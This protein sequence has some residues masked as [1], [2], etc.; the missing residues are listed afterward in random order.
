MCYSV[1]QARAIPKSCKHALL[2]IFIHIYILTNWLFYLTNS[3]KNENII[4]FFTLFG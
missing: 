4:M 2:F 1:I 3:V